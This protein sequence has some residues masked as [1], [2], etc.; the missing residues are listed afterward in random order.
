M[1]GL[2]REGSGRGQGDRRERRRWSGEDKRRIVAETFESGASVS[3]VARRHD[4][5]TNTL[6][7]WR[8]EA[9]QAAG[10]MIEAPPSFVPARI[11]GEPA[12]M[13]PPLGGDAAGR[14]EIVLPDGARVIVAA[15][16]DATA[17]GRVMKVL[18]R[19]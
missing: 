16:F 5:N 9:R 18:S 8:R 15:D 19:R 14:I 11:A 10:P 12:A 13:S 6:F 7:T 2:G 17:L 3:L 4:L 1:S